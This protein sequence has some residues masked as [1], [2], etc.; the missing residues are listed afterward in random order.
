MKVKRQSGRP[1]TDK[2]TLEEHAEYRSGVGN[3]HW[4]TSQTRPDHAVDTSRLQKRQNA[5]TYGD[6]KDLAKTIKEIKGTASA[7]LTTDHVSV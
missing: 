4:V 3:M 6:L 5:P 2:C 1:E 7:V